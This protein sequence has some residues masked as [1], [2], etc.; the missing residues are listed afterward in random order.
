MNT[1]SLLFFDRKSSVTLEKFSDTVEGEGPG[2][3]S[4]I[5]SAEAGTTEDTEVAIPSDVS[6]LFSRVASED[7]ALPPE[8]PVVNETLADM[9]SISYRLGWLDGHEDLRKKFVD[10]YK[11]R[12]RNRE[13]ELERKILKLATLLNRKNS[14]IA[15]LVEEKKAREESE[16][17]LASQN[18]QLW[19]T[20]E[21]L[22]HARADLVQTVSENTTRLQSVLAG[23]REEQDT[24]MSALKKTERR[25]GQ[26]ERLLPIIAS[27]YGKV[28][29]EKTA[30]IAQLKGERAELS[31]SIRK[32][33]RENRA[34]EE[35]FRTLH[36]EQKAILNSLMAS[37][38]REAMLSRELAATRDA[39][40]EAG[41]LIPKKKWWHFW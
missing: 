8:P 2:I 18:M 6:S 23:I 30:Q 15:D 22:R 12:F 21:E 4:Y 11:M 37:R 39:L 36:G 14:Q 24:L 34:I 13:E 1:V 28:L 9:K 19:Q 3:V 27:R 17:K 7:G 16:K 33:S 10:S 5:H 38:K 32:I 31:E 40:C 29:S 26:L 20:A 35:A 41:L 25:K